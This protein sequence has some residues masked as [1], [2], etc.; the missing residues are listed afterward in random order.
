MTPASTYLAGTKASAEL[1]YFM[2]SN[3][4]V[5]QYY[6]FLRLGFDG[7]REM[8]EKCFDRARKL[9]AGLENSG[10][11]HCISE[12]D[13]SDAYS[14]SGSLPASRISPAALSSVPAP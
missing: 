11:F 4:V 3:I 13:R 9:S 1:R 8:I 12:I 5:I 2:S 7:Y 14:F 6:N 10:I